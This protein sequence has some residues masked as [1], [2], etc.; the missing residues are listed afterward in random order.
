MKTKTYDKISGTGKH[1]ETGDSITTTYKEV[2]ID[3]PETDEEFA[4]L[5]EMTRDELAEW[6]FAYKRYLQYQS[7]AR[8][9]M[10]QKEADE[11]VSANKVSS[12]SEASIATQIRNLK[13]DGKLPPE[14]EAQIKDTLKNL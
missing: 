5:S 12:R 9:G 14:I 6:G 13:K 4:E 10:K 8:R 3:I 1:S 11:F 7:C 2:E